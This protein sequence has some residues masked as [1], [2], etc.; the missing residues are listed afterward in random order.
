MLK[1]EQ[2]G[3]RVKNGTGLAAHSKVH[4]NGHG[5]L[6]VIGAAKSN[7]HA[8]GNGKIADAELSSIAEIISAFELL[9]ERSQE[10]LR[11][12]IS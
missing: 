8:N 3:K 11:N 9:P 10:Y 1:C 4:R 5:S 7:G 2:C 6:T 12:R